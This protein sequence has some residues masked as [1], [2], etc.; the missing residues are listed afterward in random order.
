MI[1]RRRRMME[2]SAA[3]GFREPRVIFERAGATFQQFPTSTHCGTRPLLSGKPEK[4]LPIKR[5]IAAATSQTYSQATV[6]VQAAMLRWLLTTDR[7][8]PNSATSD[9][10]HAICQ[11]YA[12]ARASSGLAYD[13]IHG[14]ARPVGELAEGQCFN[15]D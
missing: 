15:R 11:R 14:S 6:G 4:L 10:P 5:G 8:H 7:P 12:Q 3:A 13:Q 1:P 9:A 2:T